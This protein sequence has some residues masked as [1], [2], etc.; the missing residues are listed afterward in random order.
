M[1]TMGLAFDIAIVNTPL[2]AVLEIR[3]ELQRMQDARDILVIGERGQLVFH[4]APHPSRLG[5][6]SEVNAG[7]IEAGL[8]FAVPVDFTLLLV[9]RATADLVSLEPVPAFAAKGAD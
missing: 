4:V 5:Y 6:F 8:P 9:R 1:H 2:E 3:D 7:A